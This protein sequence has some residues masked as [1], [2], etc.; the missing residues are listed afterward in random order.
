MAVRTKRLTLAALFTA[1]GILLPLAFHLTG[2]PA[3]GQIFLPM[4]IPVLLCG[5]IL[6]PVY[7]AVCGAICPVAG[8]LLMNMPA[9]DR[10]LFMTAELCA[11]GLAAGLFYRKCGLDR[12]RFGV[13]PALLGS[14]LSGR[15]VY[16]LALTAAATLFGLENLSAYMA[17][18]AAVTGLSGIAVQIVVLPPLVK[19]FEKS[20]FAHQL[21]LRTDKNALLREAKKL[22]QS[23]GCTLAVVFAGGG[24]FTS[25]G[26]G[27]RPLLECIDRYGAALRGAAV[28]DRVTGRAAA[29]LYAGAG[30]TAVYAAVLSREAEEA[31]KQHGIQIE[32]DT[33]VP[34]IVNR[35]GDGLCPMETSVLGISDPAEARKAIERRL[36]ELTAQKE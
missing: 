8:F 18:Q 16:A 9:A 30:V 17:V 35:T 14:M 6:G 33:L 4:H 31:L 27:V 21:G 2:I 7:G 24:R 32:A 34:R 13:Y 25:D 26:K 29:L 1:L 10:V 23:E 12:L 22:L 5:L 20:T 11:Y 36:A 3:A 15:A 28:A 19:L